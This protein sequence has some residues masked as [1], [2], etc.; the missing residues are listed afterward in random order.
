MSTNP[1]A[2]GSGSAQMTTPGSTDLGGAFGMGLPYFNMSAEERSDYVTNYYK[3]K[4]AQKLTANDVSMGRDEYETVRD[5]VFETYQAELVALEDLQNLNLT[6]SISLATQVDLWPKMQEVDGAS[7]TMDGEAQSEHATLDYEFDGV[8]VPIFHSDVDISDRYLMTTQRMGNDI[9]TDLVAAHTRAVAEKVEQLI[10]EGWGPAVSTERGDNYT[11]Y[12][13]RNHPDR[14]TV[15]GADFGTASNIRDVF[16]DC[17]N[18]MDE[19]NQTPAGDGY[20]TY[21]APPQWREF[22]SAI[23]PDG[24]GNMTV[25]ERI[26]NEFD[27]ELRQVRRAEYLPDGEMVMVNP[28]RDVVEWAEAEPIQT[29]EWESGS[30]MTNFFKIFTSGALELKSDSRGQSGLVHATGL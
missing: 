8:P 19:D 4:E 11:L 18:A 17:L 2:S 7:A 3:Q 26:N 12:G 13:Y 24:D 23:D 27:Q 5:T 1:N 16:V 21:L 6:R 28:R 20:L 22:R 9:R 14:N 29:L 30:G 10:F 25:R 15:S